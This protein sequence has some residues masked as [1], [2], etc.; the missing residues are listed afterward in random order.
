[1]YEYVR[2]LTVFLYLNNDVE[3]GGAT[4]FPLLD[5][6][7]EPKRGRALII[8]PTT[9]GVLDEDPRQMDPMTNHQAL[10]VTKGLKYGAN[11]WLHQ[12][13]METAIALGC[14]QVSRKPRTLIK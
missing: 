14:G 3:E 12:R 6:T 13:V 10:P 8:W 4:N 1:M 11:A 7:V 9:V 2:I 5:L